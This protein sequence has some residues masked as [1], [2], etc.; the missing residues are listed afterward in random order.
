MN[1]RLLYILAVTTC[2]ILSGIIGHLFLPREHFMT[3]TTQLVVSEEAAPPP[4][5]PPAPL[6][7]PKQLLDAA[8]ARTDPATIP[9]YAG[10]Y[11]IEQN[12]DKD[13][14]TLVTITNQ[15][16]Q[17]RIASFGPTQTT[18]TTER[19]ALMLNNVFADQAKVALKK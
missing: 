2:L 4:V 16:T 19:V 10:N 11:A 14:A 15:A 12:K 18:L 13:G 6:T 3:A 17:A 5:P 1:V 7:I 8:N 9:Y